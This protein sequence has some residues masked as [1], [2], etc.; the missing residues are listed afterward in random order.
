[1]IDL[2]PTMAEHLWGDLSSRYNGHPILPMEGCSLVPAFANQL[3]EPPVLF[4]EYPPKRMPVKS[5]TSSSG[6]LWSS[7]DYLSNQ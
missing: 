4:G 1:M 5:H 3:N 7:L 6:L 2:I